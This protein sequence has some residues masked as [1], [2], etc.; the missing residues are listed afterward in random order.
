MTPPFLSVIVPIYNV[1]KYLRQ[2][3]D[4]I[5]DQTFTDFEL[6]LVDDGSPDACPAICD[7]YKKKDTRIKV[8]HKKNEGLLEARKSGVRQAI[9]QYIGFVDSDDWI[10]HSM[11]ERLTNAAKSTG[12]DMVIGN[13]LRIPEK[14]K[15]RNFANL[16]PSGVYDK[17]AL[18]N[19]VYPVMLQNR[20]LYGNRHIQPSVCLKIFKRSLISQIYASMKHD[21]VI[22]EDMA[23]TYSCLFAADSLYVMDDSFKEY[24]YR[25][26][27]DS[28]SW[29]YKKD[30]FTQSM[31]LCTF[32]KNNPVGLTIPEY[33]Q[34]MNYEFCF[35]A[36]QAYYNLYL[37]RNSLTKEEKRIQMENIVNDSRILEAM[38]KIDW[39]TLKF[40]N[41][42]MLRILATG[43]IKKIE[44]MG[45][46]LS[47]LNP[48]IMQ[49]TKRIL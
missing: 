28:V 38:D 2:C 6:I 17:S 39:Q 19:K 3:L 26:N 14:G 32:L 41:T 24:Y 25:Y 8:I 43:N 10:S 5:L 22:G 12:S 36:I 37:T 9:G 30:L 45:N 40:P 48:L 46:M 49:I 18:I 42:M 16:L 1:E 15:S 4:S 47:F 27:S 29:R 34:D 21:V 35:F 31:N 44:R 7:E 13:G 11:Y 23:C 20:D 33:Q